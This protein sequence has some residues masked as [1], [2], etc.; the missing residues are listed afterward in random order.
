MCIRDRAYSPEALRFFAETP[1]GPVEAIEDINELRF[2]EHGKKLQMIP[3]EAKT[4]S[5]EM[6]I[7]D[8]LRPALRLRRLRGRL[9]L[10]CNQLSA[11]GQSAG[12][13]ASRGPE[14]SG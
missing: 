11:G 10:L 9:F 4:L 7:R 5:V 2:I 14:N 1:K 12:E 3:V 13:P 6:C 8:R